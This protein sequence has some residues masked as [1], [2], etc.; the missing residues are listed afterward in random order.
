MTDTFTWAAQTASSGGS[1][2]RVKATKFGDGYTQEVEDGL[3]SE[4][5]TA[6]LSIEGT[7]A[8]LAPVVAFLRGHKATPF[9]WTPPMSTQAYFKCRSYKWSPLDGGYRFI[10]S[11]EFEQT[12]AP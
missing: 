7:E 10:L 11:M 8:E 2:F 4:M 3:N 9:F 5:Q 6:S 1:E 12:F